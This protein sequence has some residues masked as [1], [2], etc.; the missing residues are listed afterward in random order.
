[1]DVKSKFLNGDVKLQSIEPH[2]N[3][4]KVTGSI[5]GLYP[6]EVILNGDDIKDIIQCSLN[7]DLAVKTV[8]MSLDSFFK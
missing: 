7:L 8:K 1:M 5:K 6:I 4:L 3:S 2:D